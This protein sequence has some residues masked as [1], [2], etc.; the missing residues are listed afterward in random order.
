MTLY[1]TLPGL[2][3]KA[4]LNSS[5]NPPCYKIQHSSF[6]LSNL[7]TSWRGLPAS[8]SSDLSRCARGFYTAGATSFTQHSL[9]PLPGRA[10]GYLPESSAL[11]A[12]LQPGSDRRGA[13]RNHPLGDLQEVA[14]AALASG[15]VTGTATGPHPATE[16]LPFSVNITWSSIYSYLASSWSDAH[17]R[18]EKRK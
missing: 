11:W 13:L 8:L 2:H 16:A 9:S 14:G 4:Y 18:E 17:R 12:L 6:F 7:N 15:L 5:F 10:R 3:S 1:L